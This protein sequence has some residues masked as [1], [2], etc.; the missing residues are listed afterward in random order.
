MVFVKKINRYK[1]Y[2]R[3]LFQGLLRVA[4]WLTLFIY[5][6]LDHKIPV[7]KLFILDIVNLDRV[8]SKQQSSVCK[9]K[10]FII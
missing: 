9:D 4:L 6:K 3:Y 1:F 2:I 7:G 8:I 5:D 10:E